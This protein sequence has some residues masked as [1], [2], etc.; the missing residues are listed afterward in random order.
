MYDRPSV[1]P[2]LER[3]PLARLVRR[4]AELFRD[5]RGGADIVGPSLA[6]RAEIAHAVQSVTADET[7]AFVVLDSV[8]LLGRVE[9]LRQEI[10]VDASLALSA[11]AAGPPAG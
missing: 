6:L 2:R 10:T 11:D 3:L 5:R 4:T 9:Q 7:D 8:S 1:D